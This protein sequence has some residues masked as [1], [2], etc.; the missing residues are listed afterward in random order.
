[1]KVLLVLANSMM[2]NMVHIGVA[3]LSSFLKKQ[4]H[5]VELFD[6]T[7]Y[8]TKEESGDDARSKT[9]QVKKTNLSQYGI[10]LK[11][12]EV[13]DA[14]EKAVKEYNPKLILL[15]SIEATMPLGL[16]LLKKV[17]DHDSI[18]IIGGVRA[19]F[20]PTSII[21][22]ESVDG[23]CIG[24]G[25]EAVV[26]LAN[27][28]EK[29]EDYTNTR[30][31]WFK[32]D[33]DIIKNPLGP[34][35]DLD[36]LP[37]QDWSIYEKTR[38]YKPMAGKIYIAGCIELD[39]GCPYACNFCINRAFHELYG[40][41]GRFYRERKVEN[42]IDEIKYLRDKYNLNYIYFVAENILGM[43]DERFEKFY[44]LYKD[45]KIPFFINTRAETVKADRIKKLEEMGCENIAVGIES[46]DEEFRKKYLNRH[47][48]NEIIIKAI[49]IIKQN[50]KIR[51]SVNNIVGFPFETRENI[52]KT[53]ELN[54]DV[55]ADTHMVNIFNP[56]KG[57][58]LR[59]MAIEAGF[60]SKDMDAGDYRSD[61]LLDMPQLSKDELKGLHKTFLLYVHFPKNLWPLIKYCEKQD[62]F[63]NKLFKIMSDIYRNMKNE[64]NK[65]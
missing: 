5:E 31:F 46:G 25:E 64:K 49:D 29:G 33:N 15:S 39:R 55:K 4:G 18:K 11:D 2:D 32:K 16:S 9:L 47:M 38:F 14:F 35:I 41:L 63:G 50:S 34:L 20:D 59:E 61:Y 62:E 48:S 12:E 24:E 3:L 1:M 44:Q 57:T 60:I 30:N 65:K 19:T 45:I 17:K 10:K 56:F 42:V 58:K 26:E 23:V 43:K 40:G 54:R 6:T 21:K 28:L 13:K 27:K 36:K 37:F 52:F 7:F 51:V 53:I 22:E 8:K